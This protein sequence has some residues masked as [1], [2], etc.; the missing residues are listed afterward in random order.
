MMTDAQKGRSQN[1]A[2]TLKQENFCLAYIETG[3]ASEAYR[4]AYECGKMKP[5]SI[6]R[7]AKANLDNIK[8][9]SRI[10][11]LKKPIQERHNITIDSLIAELEEARS[12]G[13]KAN[14]PQASAAIKAT[15][16]KAQLLGFLKGDSGEDDDPVG[17]V[18]VSIKSAKRTD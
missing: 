18:T 9:A 6:N 15:L 5:E 17:T 3:N 16:G 1:H 10:A 8:I 12:I 11:E 13:L 14:T 4:R 2:L 7:L